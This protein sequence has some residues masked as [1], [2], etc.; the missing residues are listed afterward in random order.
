M[1]VSVFSIWLALIS[2]SV[3]IFKPNYQAPK[4]KSKT[5]LSFNLKSRSLYTTDKWTE[6][7]R[8]KGH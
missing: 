8:E 2:E 3:D 4:K 5:V 6:T 1:S 7:R